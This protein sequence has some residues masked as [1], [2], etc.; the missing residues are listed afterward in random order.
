M[1]YS[2]GEPWP[3]RGA[4]DHLSIILNG[5][6]KKE[7]RMIVRVMMMERTFEN[8]GYCRNKS[9]ISVSGGHYG[10]QVLHCK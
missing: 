8:E 9:L 3:V 2:R 7:H 10:T 4:V 6:G 5:E 1:H